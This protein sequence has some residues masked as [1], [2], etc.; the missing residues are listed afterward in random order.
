[1]ANERNPLMVSDEDLTMAQVERSGPSWWQL[2]QALPGLPKRAAS[3]L[4]DASLTDMVKGMG[5]TIKSGAS[6][7]TDVWRNPQMMTNPLTGGTS[8]EAV[9]R[10]QDMYLG[11]QGLGLPV[12]AATVPAN[13]LGSLIGKGAKTWDPAMAETARIA[14]K[15]G[16]SPEQVWRETGISGKGFADNMLRSEIS[17]IGAKIN[18]AV[19]DKSVFKLGNLLEHPE[20]YK[21]YPELAN[22]VVTKGRMATSDILGGYD[23]ISN[24][25]M[26]NSDR[27]K[28]M[29]MEKL[30]NVMLHE[31]GHKIEKQEGF[32][33]GGDFREFL[34]KDFEARYQAASERVAAAGRGSGADL[35]NILGKYGIDPT[36][37][38]D[39]IH[40]LAR[41][42]PDTLPSA[43]ILAKYKPEVGG[44]LKEIYGH[45]KL[46]DMK[47][48]I[49]NDLLPL[50]D[51]RNQA[52]ENYRRLAGEVHQRSV[53]DRSLMTAPEMREMPPWFSFDR[54][55]S[56]H[57]VRFDPQAATAYE[58]APWSDPGFAQKQDLG[59]LRRDNPAA[60]DYKKM[61]ADSV[62][63]MKSTH[64]LPNGYTIKVDPNY[65]PSFGQAA[66]YAL[67]SPQGHPVLYGRSPHDLVKRGFPNDEHAK[68][69]PHVRGKE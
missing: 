19:L 63:Q 59:R 58:K 1:M 2:L 56:Q 64:M 49:K 15:M 51:I 57:I 61:E 17:D 6:L 30:R 25:I 47:R 36:K 38:G 55:R 14:E 50:E 32:A 24:S 68:L 54:P 40:H 28:N 23:P 11:M 48:T 29:P 20:L 42:M 18:P 3:A 41:N 67:F 22:T 26:L 13:T 9:K 33:R 27:L 12:A 69:L 21:A 34:P 5:H 37:S 8:D 65:V 60:Y 39:I 35:L 66:N 62:A 4:V 16:V 53:M 7:P 46:M 52:I 45:K 44:F 31:V 43:D 10:S